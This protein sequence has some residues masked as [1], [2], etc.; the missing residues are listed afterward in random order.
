MIFRHTRILEVPQA[1]SL[2]GA[3]LEDIRQEFQD[4]RRD[5]VID[6]L[7]LRPESAQLE[8]R[9]GRPYETIQGLYIPR[10]LRLWNVRQFKLDD[11]YSRLDSAPID[12]R[13]LQDAYN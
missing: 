4:D 12:H 11:L 2:N 10:R 13:R 5:V 3:Y 8:L 1:D 7:E 9:G 6:Y